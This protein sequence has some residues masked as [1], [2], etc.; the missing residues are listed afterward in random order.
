MEHFLQRKS[1]IRELI[2]T[3]NI[4]KVIIFKISNQNPKTFPLLLPKKEVFL[5]KDKYKK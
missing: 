1:G 5:Q 3:T 2:I 4:I